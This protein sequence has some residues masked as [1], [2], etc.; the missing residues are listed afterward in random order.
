MDAGSSRTRLI[1]AVDASLRRLGTDYIDLFYLHA[2]DAGTPVEEVLSTL[3]T[4]VRAGKIRYIGVSNFSG[5]H[6]MKSLAVS[7]TLRLAALCRAS[8][9]LFAG[10]ARL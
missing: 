6:L 7:E 9:L 4:L 10:R 5:W 8:G 3:D 1:K 2:F